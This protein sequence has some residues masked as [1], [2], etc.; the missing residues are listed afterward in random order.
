MRILQVVFFYVVQRANTHSENWPFDKTGKD[1][2]H[3]PWGLH[4]TIGGLSKVNRTEGNE[5]PKKDISQD[6]TP[7]VEPLL[8]AT[9]A[10]PIRQ[11]PPT[12]CKKHI[13]EECKSTLKIIIN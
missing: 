4:K 5:T 8:K 12:A 6:K 2:I 1:K 7:K 3:L 11:D 9:R 10:S 13:P